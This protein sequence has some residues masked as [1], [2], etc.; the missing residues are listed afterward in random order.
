MRCLG[1]VRYPTQDEAETALREVRAW[2]RARQW[3]G[4]H[5]QNTYECGTCGSWHLT[6]MSER[7]RERK[8]Q[9]MAGI[10]ELAEVSDVAAVAAGEEAE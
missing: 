5:E 1:K 9:L 3:H 2:R 4:K 10:A 8:A 7:E 6:S